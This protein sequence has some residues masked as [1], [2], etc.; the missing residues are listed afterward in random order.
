MFL[1]FHNV[2][3]FTTELDTVYQSEWKLKDYLF[4]HFINASSA[5]KLNRW[6]YNS[7]TLC[8]Y[9]FSRFGETLSSVVLYLSLIRCSLKS[10]DNTEVTFHWTSASWCFLHLKATGCTQCRDSR[11]PQRVSSADSGQ[12]FLSLLYQFFKPI[13]GCQEIQVLR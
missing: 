9:S 11:C 8:I 4:E 3:I 6:C 7:I 13:P 5:I 1:L 2:S 12:E 10:P